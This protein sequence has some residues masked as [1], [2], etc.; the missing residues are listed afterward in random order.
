MTTP[1]KKKRHR[2]VRA[3]RARLVHA[4]TGAGLKTQAALAERIADLEDLEAM[5]KDAVSR[6]FRELPVEPMTLE[7]IARALGVEAHTLYKTAEEEQDEMAVQKQARAGRVPLDRRLVLAGVAFAALLLFTYT[8]YSG[9]GSDPESIDAIAALDLGSTPVVV[10]AFDGDD[11]GAFRTVLRES[12][13]DHFQVSSSTAAALVDGLDPKTAADRL[14][15]DAVISGEF[16]TV[17]RLTAVRAYLFANDFR[18]QIWSESWPRHAVP[19]KLE[20]IAANISRALVRTTGLPSND[21]E[22]GYFPLAPVQDDYLQGELYLDAPSSELNIK[23]AQSRFESALR[24]DANYAR[25]HAGLCQTLMEEHWMTD[26]ERALTDAAATCGQALQLDPDDPVI[27]A[28]HAHFLRRTGRNEEALTLYERVTT[29]HPFD[30]SALYGLANS[31]LDQ[32]LQSEDPEALSRAKKAARAAAIADEKI[33]KPLFALATMEW[34]DGNLEAATSVSEEALS[35]DENEKILSNLGTFYIC[36]GNFEKARDTYLRAQEINPASYVGDEFLGQ[37]YYFVGDYAESAKLRKR[38]IESIAGGEPE[39]H[40]M[41]GSLGDSY[42]HLGDVE[43]AMDAY[44]KAASIAERDYLRGTSPIADRAARAYYYV[45]LDSLDTSAVSKA[46]M[47][48]IYHDIDAIAAEV[49]TGTAHRRMAVIYLQRNQR[50]KARQALQ[51]ATATCP[52]YAKMADFSELA[53]S[54]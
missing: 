24:Q 29:A 50:D 52:G 6:V 43:G 38:A 16:L 15:A 5:P 35:R 23:R 4:M 44:R 51:E 26:E 47:R 14:R 36:A 21:A 32:F 7:R 37:V 8:R 10:M 41:W 45:M 39:I 33:W 42:R 2:G 46:V 48:E 31:R 30:A 11:N 18:T 3:S 22:P 49:E 25:A 12:L 54:T 20:N 27:A 9:G 53:S 28:A 17:G 40:Q 1:D 34:Y 13:G 19:N